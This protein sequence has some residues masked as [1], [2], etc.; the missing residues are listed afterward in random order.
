MEFSNKINS[1]SLLLFI[2]E[3]R[4]KNKIV[5]INTFRTSSLFRKQINQNKI[6]PIFSQSRKKNFNDLFKWYLILLKEF[7]ILFN[8][9]FELF[10]MENYMKNNF[11]NALKDII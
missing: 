8:S 5:K 6:N 11:V 9:E 10:L 7:K 1:L 2:F 4:I 3:H